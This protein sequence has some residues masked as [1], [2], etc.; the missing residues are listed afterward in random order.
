MGKHFCFSLLPDFTYFTLKLGQNVLFQL[1]WR[2]K[3]QA[4]CCTYLA[5]GSS[6][7]ACQKRMVNGCKYTKSLETKHFVTF[8]FG[9][10]INIYN[11]NSSRVMIR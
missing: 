11:L 10:D 4:G 9:I 2:V 5:V 3:K 8:S 1:L 7:M 6:A